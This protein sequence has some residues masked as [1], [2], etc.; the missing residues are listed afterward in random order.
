MEREPVPSNS[1]MKPYTMGGNVLYGADN[2]AAAYLNKHIPGGY[3]LG[4]GSQAHG[5]MVG[6]GS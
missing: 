1:G 2:I 4:P 5:V 3:R 6:E